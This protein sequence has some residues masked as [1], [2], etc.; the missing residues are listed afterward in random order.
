[1]H[2]F[3]STFSKDSFQSPNISK[4]TH[5]HTHT[6]ALHYL[7]Q[8]GRHTHIHTDTG[9]CASTICIPLILLHGTHSNPPP[10][11]IHSTPTHTHTPVQGP[12]YPVQCRA[13]WS[14]FLCP[15]SSVWRHSDTWSPRLSPP[16]W[17]FCSRR[18]RAKQHRCNFTT[19]AEHTWGCT[20]LARPFFPLSSLLSM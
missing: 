2:Y 15:L 20:V 1:M 4:H 3:E 6:P 8:T 13:W 11:P 19:E 17:L 9:L 12:V 16:R 18:K 14:P 7:T 5:T 10:S